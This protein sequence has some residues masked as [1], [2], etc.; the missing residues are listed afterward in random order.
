VNTLN[1][2][3]GIYLIRELHCL[4]NMH[5]IIHSLVSFFHTVDLYVAYD[6]LHEWYVTTFYFSRWG[7]SESKTSKSCQVLEICLYFL[8]LI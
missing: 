4:K 3:N 7:F 8:F 1:V 2:F 5:G 6:S